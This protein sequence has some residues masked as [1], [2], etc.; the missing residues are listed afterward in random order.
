MRCVG[1]SG[2][3]ENEAERFP[4][5]ATRAGSNKKRG[6]PH[7]HLGSVAQKGVGLVHSRQ[8]LKLCVRKGGWG[9]EGCAIKT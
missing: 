1:W 4:T 3:R 2:V 6:Q 9:G 5:R 8:E 7:P